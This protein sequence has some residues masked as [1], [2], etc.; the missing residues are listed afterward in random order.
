MD[1]WG[2]ER[3]ESQFA[4]AGKAGNSFNPSL[5]RAPDGQLYL[6]HNDES[7]HDGIHRW[8]IEGLVQEL[9]VVE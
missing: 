1:F 6:Y 2:A 8:R 4:V 7:Q 9:K 5:A 3:R